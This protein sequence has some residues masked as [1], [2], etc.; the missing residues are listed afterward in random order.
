MRLLTLEDT[1]QRLGV[2]PRSLADKRYRA[3]IG[4]PGTKI[5]RRITFNE[6][7]VTKLIDRCR[8]PLPKGISHGRN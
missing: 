7:D 2:S 4:L 6:A 5:G 1:A 3:R 8:E